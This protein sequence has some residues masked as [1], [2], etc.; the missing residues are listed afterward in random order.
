[1]LVDET[2]KQA[3]EAGNQ[4]YEAGRVA[5]AEVKFKEALDEAEKFGEA[6]LRLALSLNNLAA[7]YHTQGKYTIA[8]PLYTRSLAIKERVHGQEHPEIALNLHNLAVLYSARRMYPVAEKYYKMTIDLK[9][10]LYGKDDRQ[11][12]NTLRYYAQLL[13]ALNRLVDQALVESRLKDISGKL[14]EGP[15]SAAR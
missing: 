13:K 9:E 6:D 2:W 8:E 4:A 10:K 7:I 1:M 15:V 12:I 11:L 3:V 5:E 14:P